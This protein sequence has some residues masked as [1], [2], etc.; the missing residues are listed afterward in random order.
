MADSDS[1]VAP[2]VKRREQTWGYR[3]EGSKQALISSGLVQASW[4]AD[5]T[6]RNKRGH[7]V[8][9]K[10]L[11]VDGCHIHTYM[12][13]PKRELFEVWVNYP[14]AERDARERTEEIERE[15]AAVR[16][17][18]EALP[19]SAEA[20]RESFVHF[21]GIYVRGVAGQAKEGEAGYR[22]DAETIETLESL[23]DE[24]VEAIE[25][26]RIL[27][28][29]KARIAAEFKIRGNGDPLEDGAYLDFKGKMT[30]Q[31]WT[32]DKELCAEADAL[33]KPEP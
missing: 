16:R 19:K 24:M 30:P 32:G 20:Y 29:R 9:T 31:G 27:F 7:T 12:T 22:Y 11:T 3:L 23:A 18:I 25:N 15:A 6:E 5:G 2:G 10:H 13:N 28:D 4:L 14:K 17:K 1:T 26:G 33:Y 21:F 8:R